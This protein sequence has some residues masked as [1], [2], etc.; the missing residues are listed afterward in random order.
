MQ[1]AIALVVR[2]ATATIFKSPFGEPRRARKGLKQNRIILHF[3]GA[4]EP[5]VLELGVWQ[6]SSGRRRIN[7]K[8]KMYFTSES[9]A[10]S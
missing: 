7:R 1:R 6:D 5:K 3:R 9:E 2:H 10:F 4:A 8:S